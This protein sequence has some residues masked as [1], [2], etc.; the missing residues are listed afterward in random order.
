[1]FEYML[2]DKYQYREYNNNKDQ[3]TKLYALDHGNRSRDITI[4]N[5]DLYYRDFYIGNKDLKYFEIN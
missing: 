2:K 4:I 5:Q 1:M 3:N